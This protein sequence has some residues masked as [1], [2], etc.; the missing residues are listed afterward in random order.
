[1][2]A[3]VVRPHYMSPVKRLVSLARATSALPPGAWLLTGPA[4]VGRNHVLLTYQPADRFWV[5]QGIETGV[6]VLLAAGLLL[7]AHRM[8]VARDA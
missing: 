3:V 7:L 6:F 5:F 1:V 8:V 2:I 4:S